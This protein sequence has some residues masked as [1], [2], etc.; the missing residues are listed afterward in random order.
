[1]ALTLGIIQIDKLIIHEIPRKEP[2]QQG[3]PLAVTGV[4][5]NLTQG[6]R[7]FISEKINHGLARI[8]YR[9]KF[10]LPTDSLVPDYIFKILSEDIPTEDK[11][12][13]YSQQIA[14]DLY[15]SQ[16]AINP[17][18]LLIITKVKLGNKPGIAILKLEKEEGMQYESN[19]ND[20][21][22]ITYSIEQA[23]NLMLTGGK[24]FK[25]ALFIQE[26]TTLESIEGWISDRQSGVRSN[27]EIAKFFLETFLSCY[28][29]DSPEIITKRFY[30]ASQDFINLHVEDQELKIKYEM[31]LLSVISNNENTIDPEEF[32]NSYFELNDRSSFTK[33]LSRNDIPVSAFE[34][35]TSSIESSLKSMRLSFG[36]IILYMP[37]S[38]DPRSLGDINV[39][40]INKNTV[41]ISFDAELG[42]LGK[43]R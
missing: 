5:S 21:G 26:G 30:K 20:E 25:I 10:N 38:E 42:G 29:L 37:I 23:K 6:D 32:A 41:R 39:I 40:P 14:K 28:L 33:Y 8:A 12:V 9:A 24:I 4:E 35:N 43:Q 36:D 3:I 16:T 17:A 34:K 19:F 31:A 11:F 15:Q 27:T 2:K 22:L 18:G 13:F 1:M 7:N